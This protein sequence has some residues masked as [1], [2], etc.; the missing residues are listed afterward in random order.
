M[1]PWAGGEDAP[2]CVF[3]IALATAFRAL[4][5]IYKCERREIIPFMPSPALLAV[6]FPT[7]FRLIIFQ[8]EDLDIR[9]HGGLESS[10]WNL[11]FFCDHD[12]R[13][14]MLCLASL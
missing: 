11:Q 4:G 13:A 9:H 8:H 10:R 1:F 14:N 2:S 5:Q 3:T 7:I 12:T 6:R